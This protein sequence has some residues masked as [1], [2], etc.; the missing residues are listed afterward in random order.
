MLPPKCPPGPAHHPSSAFQPHGKGNRD[1]DHPPSS[2]L[3]SNGSNTPS[4]N[5]NQPSLWISGPGGFHLM[6]R[7]A[8]AILAL[9]VL[10]IIALVVFFSLR[11]PQPPDGNGT[12]SPT[13]T[14]ISDDDTEPTSSDDHPTFSNFVDDNGFVFPNSE[15]EYLTDAE[16]TDLIKKSGSYAPKL[17]Q[18]AINEIVARHG[19]DFGDSPYAD[20]YSQ[21]KWYHC[22]PG[23]HYDDISLSAVEQAN[24]SRLA[25]YRDDLREGKKS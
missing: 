11:T 23:S 22:V 18:Y 13:Q 4:N 24:Y 8:L 3:P 10:A 20:Y 15:T 17:L 12:P 9:I 7:G 14:S 5:D 25:D 16:I 21:Y 6:A 1:D 2:Q 19:Y